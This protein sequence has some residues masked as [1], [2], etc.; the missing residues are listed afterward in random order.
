MSLLLLALGCGPAP[1]RMEPLPRMVATLPGGEEV[2]AEGYDVHARAVAAGNCGFAVSLY[3]PARTEPHDDV[4]TFAVE[5][6]ADQDLATVTTA[7]AALTWWQRG[8]DGFVRHQLT[9]ATTQLYTLDEHATLA[10]Y[11]R[12]CERTDANP[13]PD[14][15][16]E[17][18]V[19]LRSAIPAEPW[20]HVELSD[21]ENAAGQRLC[22]LVPLPH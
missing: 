7:R 13:C 19:L 22:R 10:V 4:G 1:V 21:L 6:S 15:A 8:D 5:L 12:I 3:A 20:P 18:L 16:T 17:D 9:H 14:D 11:G 2:V